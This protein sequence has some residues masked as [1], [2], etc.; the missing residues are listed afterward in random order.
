LNWS[1]QSKCLRIKL[2]I[3]SKCFNGQTVSIIID[4]DAASFIIARLARGGARVHRDCCRV[5]SDRMDVSVPGRALYTLFGA[6]PSET[7]IQRHTA[8]QHKQILMTFYTR[9]GLN[10]ILLWMPS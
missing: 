2:V 8:R 7:H 9:K 10:G 6:R 4:V 5:I 1:I 3:Q